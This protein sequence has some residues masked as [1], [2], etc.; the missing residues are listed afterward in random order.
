MLQPK[1]PFPN[2]F[3][4]QVFQFRSLMDSFLIDSWICTVQNFKVSDKNQKP[5]MN[6][7]TI[8]SAFFLWWS[9]AQVEIDRRVTKET[10][11]PKILMLVSPCQIFIRRGRQAFSVQHSKSFPAWLQSLYVPTIDNDSFYFFGW[12]L[13]WSP[14]EFLFQ[15]SSSSTIF[16]LQPHYSPTQNS[17]KA[18]YQYKAARELVETENDASKR[19]CAL[20]N[21]M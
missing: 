6:F 17:I 5:L 9:I 14:F 19:T 7:S 2:N 13:S 15:V 18:S 8:V 1:Y 20:I 21:A 12:N 16:T 10:V 3:P 11:P 4:K